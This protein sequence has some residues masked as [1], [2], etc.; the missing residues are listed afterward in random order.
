MG[1]W[2]VLGVTRLFLGG[3]DFEHQAAGVDG[4]SSHTAVQAGYRGGV[5]ETLKN[6]SVVPQREVWVLP[7]P[8]DV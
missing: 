3:G 7:R 2:G 6:E 4:G 1:A 8:D 5:Q